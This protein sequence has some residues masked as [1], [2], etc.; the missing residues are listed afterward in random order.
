MPT[1]NM[2]EMS[3]FQHLAHG[4]LGVHTGTSLSS[5]LEL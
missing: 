2:S 3:Y 4:D 5:Y 1:T